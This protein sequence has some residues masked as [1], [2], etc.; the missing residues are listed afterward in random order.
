MAHATARILDDSA[1]ETRDDHLDPVVRDGMAEKYAKGAG[2]GAGSRNEST[3]FRDWRW[4]VIEPLAVL[5]WDNRKDR[6]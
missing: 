3:A 4:I 5:S 2:P 6:R 1:A